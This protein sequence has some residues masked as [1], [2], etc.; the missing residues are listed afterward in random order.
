VR[1]VKG[2]LFGLLSAI[3]YVCMYV[4]T[5]TP[6]IRLVSRGIETKITVG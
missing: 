2:I 1:H 3:T 5:Q 6:D 4:Y